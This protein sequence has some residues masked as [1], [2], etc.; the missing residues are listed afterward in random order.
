MNCTLKGCFPVAALEGRDT[1]ASMDVAVKN[2]GI[3]GSH[4][5]QVIHARVMFLFNG[6]E[7]KAG[8]R[9]QRI[10]CSTRAYAYS[11]STGS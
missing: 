9:R 10:A 7:K 5:K 8:R 6:I 3:T 1:A 4:R 2:H 11:G